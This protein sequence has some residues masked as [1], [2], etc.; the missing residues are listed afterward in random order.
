MVCLSNICKSP[1]AQAILQSKIKENAYIDSAGIASNNIGSSQDSIS[2]LVAKEKGIDISNYKAR[3]FIKEDFK[4]LILYT[5]WIIQILK[6]LYVW[7]I[8]KKKE[9]KFL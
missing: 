7:K 9:K 2:I 8:V 4:N 3:K 1:F 5:L 6:M